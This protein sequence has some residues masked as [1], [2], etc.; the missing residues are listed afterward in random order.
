METFT[1]ARVIHVLAV[2][3]WIGGVSM[4]T[5]VIIPAVKKMKTKEDKLQTFEQIEG[6]FAT[7]AKITTLL[8]GIT[9]FYMMYEMDAW[10]RYLDIRFWWIHAMTIMWIIFT[11]VLYVLEPLLLHKLFR[12]EVEK[13]PDKAFR[14]IHR[15]H[16]ILLILSLCTIFGAVAGSHGWY[17]IG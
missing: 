15:A 9:G 5:T 11:L 10:S 2:V 17:F 12:K 6:K 7:Q 1:L 8:T 14:I 3:L 13:N 16:W 4:V